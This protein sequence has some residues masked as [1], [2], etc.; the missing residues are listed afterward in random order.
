MIPFLTTFNL[1]RASKE[2]N[3]KGKNDQNI[4]SMLED[5]LLRTWFSS[6]I[7]L[8]YRNDA[9]EH[10]ILDGFF[11]SNQLFWVDQKSETMFELKSIVEINDEAVLEK[12][13]HQYKLLDYIVHKMN[14][15]S[16]DNEVVS[17]EQ[18]GNFIIL[19]CKGISIDN[20]QPVKIQVFEEI[21][22]AFVDA[23]DFLKECAKTISQQ[24]QQSSDDDDEHKP[25]LFGQRMTQ[26]LQNGWNKMWDGLSKIQVHDKIVNN[27]P[28]MAV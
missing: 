9:A 21:V 8:A 20:L 26:G 6:A 13:Q 12:I 22:G 17:I 18:S 7:D 27:W 28:T 2:Q 16:I 3:E 5:Q 25:P 24:Q 10:E 15:H 4:H 23:V 1:K 14:K 11:T 19:R